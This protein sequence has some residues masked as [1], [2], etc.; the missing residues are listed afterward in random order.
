MEPPHIQTRLP[1]PTQ[2]PTTSHSHEESPVKM[3][4]NRDHHFQQLSASTPHP[5]PSSSPFTPPAA[6]T[7][8][9]SEGAVPPYSFPARNPDPQQFLL[10]PEQFQQPVQIMRNIQQGLVASPSAPL[11]PS[12]SQASGRMASG[13]LRPEP[14]GSLPSAPN[15]M[16][17]SG[18]RLDIGQPRRRMSSSS[19][20]ALDDKG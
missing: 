10:T 13:V 20:V 7:H 12:Y 8:P 19:G 11:P 1:Y 16:S 3:E 5:P 2:T 9:R 17:P 18:T 4:L 6:A 15:F 14:G